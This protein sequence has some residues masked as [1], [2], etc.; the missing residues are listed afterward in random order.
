MGTKRG[1][2]GRRT[3]DHADLDLRYGAVDGRWYQQEFSGQVLCES[4]KADIIAT[5][6]YRWVRLLSRLV[7]EEAKRHGDLNKVCDKC[8]QGAAS[9]DKNVAA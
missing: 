3:R 6:S 2:E 7:F 9:S 5:S 8:R 4:H 1:N